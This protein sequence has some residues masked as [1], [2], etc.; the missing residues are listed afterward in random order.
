MSFT[1]SIFYYGANTD[2]ESDTNECITTAIRTLTY[3]LIPTHI[4][5]RIEFNK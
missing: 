1:L 5:F 2:N 4:S 3:S